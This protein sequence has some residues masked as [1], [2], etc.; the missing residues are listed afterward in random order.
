MAV[1]QPTPGVTPLRMLALFAAPLVQRVNSQTVP[2]TLLSVLHELDELHAICEELE[3]PVAL[4][5]DPQIATA[6]RVGHIFATRQPFDMLH[7]TG[8]GS[9]A[10]QG[11]ALALEDDVG[12]LRL[13]FSA[14]L[15]S[16]FDEPPCRLALLSA[17]HS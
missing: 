11:V 12:A 3:P 14:E 10:Q 6:E 5:I 13:M 4:E 17:C 1:D 8:H 15:Q 7:F 9:Q 16:H 2:I